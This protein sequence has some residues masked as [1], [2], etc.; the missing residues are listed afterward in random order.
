MGLAGGAAL[1]G[2]RASPYTTGSDRT[3]QGERLEHGLCSWLMLNF[4][5]AQ[6]FRRTGKGENRVRSREGLLGRLGLCDD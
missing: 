6:G 3:C 5:A 2:D 1:P 4:R